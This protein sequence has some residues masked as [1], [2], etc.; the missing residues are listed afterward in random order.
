MKILLT[1]PHFPP[2]RI[3]GSEWE[4]LRVAR[5][6]QA[7]GHRVRVLS[8][9]EADRR[10]VPGALQGAS[11]RVRWTDDVY[12]GVLIR[13]LFLELGGLP[14][15]VEYDNELIGAQVDELLADDRP[16]LL[17]LFSGYLLT[18]RPLL[19]ARARGIAAIASLADM[20]VLCPRLHMR[21]TDGSLSTAP[22]DPLRCVRCVAE[23]QRRY[24]IP[25]RLAPQ[26]MDWYWGRHTGRI[27]NIEH[28]VE[29][30][31]QALANADAVLSRSPFLLSMLARSGTVEETRLRFV[32]PGRSATHGSSAPKEKLPS[33]QLRLGY[34]GQI[35][36][37]KGVHVVVDAVG[38]L[39]GAPLTLDLHGE[40]TQFP[41]YARRIRAVADRDPRIRCKP[42]FTGDEQLSELH[43][44]F[45]VLVMPSVWYECS[46]N[47]ILESFVY[48]TPVVASN[49]GGIAEMISD[50]VDGLLFEADNSAS[51]A[52]TIQR[53][54]DDRGLAARLREGISPV[55]TQEDEVAELENIYSRI[56]AGRF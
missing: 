8:V 4:T 37:H 34:I 16:D 51:L 48:K 7:R 27:R 56:V 18:L 30:Q 41:D 3:G 11:S 19:A 43:R 26:L 47:V 1:V 29:F 24:R 28:R 42:R 10:T 38:R 50:G 14:P 53:F 32:R 17:H 39:P 52:A 13:R 20:W 55:R 23:E 49:L 22:V 44:S 54:L 6:L 45:D 36:P 21:R 5:G 40:W 25:G 15:R 12:E 9:E 46:P 31:R 33:D 35:A 2:R